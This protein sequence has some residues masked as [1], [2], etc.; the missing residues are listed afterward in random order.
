MHLQ[1]NGDFW[2]SLKDYNMWE[3]IT[4]KQLYLQHDLQQFPVG[5]SMGFE[6]EFT[7]LKIFCVDKSIQAAVLAANN[8]V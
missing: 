4:V 5:I 7:Y 6:L 8:T 3:W 1:W 2:V